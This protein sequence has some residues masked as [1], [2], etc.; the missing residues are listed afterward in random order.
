MAPSS[1]SRG[2]LHRGRSQGLGGSRG[3][4]KR[5][6]AASHGSRPVFYGTRIEEQ[7]QS[8]AEESKSQSAE[9]NLEQDQSNGS[10]DGEE[11]KVNTNS[12]SALLQ[13]LN[14]NANTQGGPSQRKKRKTD[15]EGLKALNLE[16]PPE[17][18][19][20]DDILENAG[21]SPSGESSADE[22]SESLDGNQQS[23]PMC[24]GPLPPSN[25]HRT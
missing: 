5:T 21:S 3:K 14:R 23:T 6:H 15:G 19:L 11:I 20:E 22:E 24:I 8:D 4:G 16:K 9:E 13:S 12:Y 7:V 25:S 1:S 2:R 10:E 18:Q 17:V